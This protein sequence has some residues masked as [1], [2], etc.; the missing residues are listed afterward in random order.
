MKAADQSAN[1][2]G[3]IDQVEDLNN[4]DLSKAIDKAFASGAA[5]QMRSSLDDLPTWKAI[6]IYWRISL[7][8]MLCAFGGA[9]EGYQVAIASSIV[10][11]KGFIRQMSGGATAL[12]PSHVAVW[13]G[14]LSTGQLVGVGFLQ[15]ATDRLGRKV[16]MHITWLTLCIAVALE[17]AASNWLYWLFAKLIGGAGL[18]MMQATYPLYISEQ[19]PTQ[20][21]GFLTASYMF[22][23]V[24]AQIFA[25]LALRQLA[26]TDPYDFKIT[27]YTQWGML[28]ALLL[29]NIYIPES[30]WWLVQRSRYDNA[31]K[32]LASTHKDIPD[33]DV[34]SELSIIVATVE[35]ERF[36]TTETKNQIAQI[37]KGVNA[38]RLFI[39][40]WP[41]AMQQLA[42]QSVT[43]NYATYFFQLAGNAAPFT[44][45]I[46]LAVC[47]LVGVLSSSLISD[48][49]GR[50][51]LTLGLFGAGT[52][53]I[54][55]IGIL[56]SFD[57]QSE[58]LGSVLVFFACVSNFGVIGGAGVAYSYVVDIPSQQ[59]RSRTA[60]IALMGSYC[61]GL[62]FNYT[63]PLML[64]VWSVQTGYF[65]GAAG[66]ISCVVGFFVLP[67]ITRRTP[68]EI[69]EMFQD[70]VAPRKFR[71]HVTQVQLFLVDK[72][73]ME[74]VPG[75]EKA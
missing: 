31:E 43:N 18:G 56:G 33:Y 16:A 62:I 53:A 68:A 60:S 52:V 42:G 71:K 66:A 72:E 58:K 30:P 63:V 73:N 50:R 39:A 4:A 44:V 57:Y 14:M 32:V 3:H 37:F 22:W 21:R 51:W 7:I 25:P 49:F 9:L 15:L 26:I 38:W 34:K 8:C 35:H 19:S 28:A 55:G 11:N 48:K 41:K 5:V 69:D 6:R 74:R 36:I 10:S 17:S 46:I 47:Q 40:F 29:I 13:G 24:G 23:Y 61:L 67:E 70:K 27:I 12:N 45:T 54:L 75:D 20:I 64:K 59:L 2:T 1:M 65:F